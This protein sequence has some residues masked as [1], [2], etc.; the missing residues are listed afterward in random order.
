MSAI[1]PRRIG[2]EARRYFR[3]PM[4]FVVPLAIGIGAAVLV[5]VAGRSRGAPLVWAAAGA[6]LAAGLW[7]GAVAVQ[8]T[9]WHDV[10]G[11][12][13]CNRYCNG[14]HRFGVVTFWTP[15]VAGATLVIA[16]AAT[17]GVRLLRRRR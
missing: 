12:V 17:V 13:D 2:R 5:M 9:G 11:W 6:V 7:V 16:S 14:W 8:S 3:L 4:F 10:D 15:L 1:V